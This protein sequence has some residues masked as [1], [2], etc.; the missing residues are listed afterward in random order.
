MIEPTMPSRNTAPRR[1]PRPASTGAPGA[2]SGSA[3]SAFGGV[4]RLLSE[5]SLIGSSLGRWIVIRDAS[6]CRA[7][8]AQ[9]LARRTGRGRA[10]G[11]SHE[12]VLARV[13]AAEDHVV[14]LAD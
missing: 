5:K 6:G 9:G 13:L 4:N 3:S 11:A 1:V 10:S 8:V 2:G 14:H 12:Q 7:A